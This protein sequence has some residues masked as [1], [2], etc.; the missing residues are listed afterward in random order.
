[1]VVRRLTSSSAS[2]QLM[3]VGVRN[4]RQKSLPVRIAE[5]TTEIQ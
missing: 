4:S 3:E 5:A 2:M 1:L